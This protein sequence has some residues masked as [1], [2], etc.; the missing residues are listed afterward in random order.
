MIIDAGKIS[1]RMKAENHGYHSFTITEPC[2]K[3]ALHLDD[4]FDHV[5]CLCDGD[6]EMEYEKEIDVPWNTCKSIYKAMLST[7]E[8]ES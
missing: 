2:P 6:D 3:C 7:I 4:H 5:E 1:N 8:D